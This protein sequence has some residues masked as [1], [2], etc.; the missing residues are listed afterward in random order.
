MG[1]MDS[2]TWASALM[3]GCRL[4]TQGSQHGAG[5]ELGADGRGLP[6]Q[7]LVDLA[8]RGSLRQFLLRKF[9]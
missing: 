1:D 9:Y 5:G 8:L 2:L 6:G 3:E 4:Y 7:G